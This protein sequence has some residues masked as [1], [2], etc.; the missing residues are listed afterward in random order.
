MSLAGLLSGIRFVPFC[1]YTYPGMR[2]A[3]LCPYSVEITDL[4]ILYL[5]FSLCEE[6]I[7]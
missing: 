7:H 6:K 5:G 3:W 1:Y 2:K 4:G